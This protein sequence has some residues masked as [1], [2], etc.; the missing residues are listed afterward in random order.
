M[1][2]IGHPVHRGKQIFF[3]LLTNRV[4]GHQKT[5]GVKNVFFFFLSKNRVYGHQ[6]TQNFT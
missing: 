5:I 6:K 1:D 4:Y 3:F 2:Y